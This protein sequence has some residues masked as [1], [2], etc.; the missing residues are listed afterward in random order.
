MFSLAKCWMSRTRLDLGV[1]LD[2]GVASFLNHLC[3]EGLNA[4]KHGAQFALG[5]A[6]PSSEMEMV[7]RR[8]EIEE[9]VVCKAQ[10]MQ[11]LEEERRW[12]DHVEVNLDD[13]AVPGRG[14]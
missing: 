6:R 11:A 10:A 9:G 8:I 5:R 1:E 4:R 7:F 2:A 14:V 3:G 12:L 13:H